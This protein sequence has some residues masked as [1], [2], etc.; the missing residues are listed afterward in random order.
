MFGSSLFAGAL[1]GFVFSRFINVTTSHQL[2]EINFIVVAMAGTLA[3]IIH[4][5]L[6]A[7]FLIAEI[8][9]GYVLFIPLMI[10][11][12]ISYLITNFFEPYSVYTKRL[13]EEGKF[14]LYDRDKLILENIQLSKFIE[15]DYIPVRENDSLENLRELI[16]NSTRTIFPVID[17][18][19]KLL[20]LV[21]LDEI[22]GLMF[23]RSMDRLILVKDIMTV[24]E[25]LAEMKDSMF[26]IVRKMDE[27]NLWNL[28]VIKDGKYIGF[29][30]K[31]KILNHYRELLT[32]I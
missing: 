29:V 30:S 31:S 18:E 6:T 11:V 14:I 24:P 12:S 10:V 27:H 8:T 9:G 4:A 23:D 2:N 15:K 20:G 3:G 7:I 26:D 25:V 19:E 22:R 28:P 16:K 17:D 32:N 1:L 13:A 5:P 21:S